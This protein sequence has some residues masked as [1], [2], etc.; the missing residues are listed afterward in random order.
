MARLINPTV[1]TAQTTSEQLAAIPFLPTLSVTVYQS[2]L[3]GIYAEPGF[4]DV[5]ADDL[6]TATELSV[7]QVAGALG[8]LVEHGLVW[9]DD[10]TVNNKKHR[11]LFPAFWIGS[12]TVAGDMEPEDALKA[13]R[14]AVAARLGGKQQKHPRASRAGKGRKPAPEPKP[15]PNFKIKRHPE[16]AAGTD[17]WVLVCAADAV[18]AREKAIRDGYQ[19]VGRAYPIKV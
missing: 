9:V 3:N 1:E 10:T 5:E 13:A 11:F 16:F 14:E 4:S 15:V 2:L 12:R 19:V 6:V 18:E 17:G 8:Y 7:G